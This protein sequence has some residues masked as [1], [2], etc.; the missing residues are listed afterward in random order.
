MREQLKWLIVAPLAMSG[1]GDSGGMTASAGATDG[2]SGTT[3]ATNSASATEPTGGSNSLSDSVTE[4]TGGS[5]SLSDSQVSL[6]EPTDSN[7]NSNTDSSSNSSSATDSASATDTTIGTTT[8]T[9]GDTSTGT[10]GGVDTDSSSTGGAPLVCDMPP[11]GFDGPDDPNCDIEPQVGAFNP[12]AEWSKS[13]WSMGPTFTQVMAAPIVVRLTDDNADGKIDDYDVPDIVFSTFAVA[14]T[15]RRVAAGGQRQ[16]R[17]GDPEH[18]Q[19]V[20]QWHL[21]CCRR[22]YRR[23]RDRRVDRGDQRRRGQGLRAR[24]Y[25]QVDLAGAG[26]E[27]LLVPGDRRHER[28]RQ[29]GGDRRQDDPE[30]RRDCAGDREVRLWRQL[31][32]SVVVDLDGDGNQELVG[33]NAVYDVDGKEQW[34]NAALAMA[35]SAS[36][37]WTS[38][39][40]RT[41]WS[42]AAARCA[43]RTGQGVVKWD[44]AFPG[45]GGGPPTIADYDADGQPEI[46]VAGKTGDVVFESDG[47]VLWQKPTQDASS[48]QT[49]SSVYDFEGDGAADVVYND[50]VRLR[51][52]A[53]NNGAEKLNILGHGSGTLY[54]YPL[55]VDVDNDGQSEI[56]VINNNYAY[57]T[58]AGVTVYGDKDKSWRPARKIWNQHAYYITNVND[59]GTI[60][61]VP[62]PNYKAYNNFRSGDLSPPDG[63][64]TPDAT[65]KVPEPCVL[66]C[67]DGKLVLW[68]HA[69]NKGASPV[70]TP[71]TIEVSGV[72]NGV[73]TPLGQKQL[74]DVID[75]GKYLDAVAFE[76]DPAGLESITVKISVKEQECDLGNNE[77]VVQ[78]PFCQ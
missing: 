47:K 64:K 51:V 77:V 1:C 10:S 42:S 3:G 27:H 38:T 23:R 58:K 14:G 16:R 53:G 5:N 25:A 52:Y 35:G 71:T 34:Y 7:S 6:T 44:V 56:V 24:R 26:R 40:S 15:A 4:P 30:Q 41:S 74:L 31:V 18:R 9:T 50:E 78:G 59:D 28:R 29:A 20:D 49:G 8:T 70:T 45:G 37:T 62:S 57:G 32:A 17:Q 46:G 68:V 11:A 61:A 43:C 21:G 54:E 22:R 48:Q 55:V 19:P 75:P 67:K 69:G 76:L 65:L 33:G 66:E 12:V 36:P 73:E 13:T 60:P 72:V 39:P 63:K 2:G